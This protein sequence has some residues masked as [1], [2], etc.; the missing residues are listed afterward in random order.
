MGK[1]QEVRSNIIGGRFGL[2]NYLPLVNEIVITEI[3]GFLNNI[4]PYNLCGCLNCYQCIVCYFS[5]NY[6]SHLR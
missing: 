1:I 4:R 2:D 5:L 3:I 6:F